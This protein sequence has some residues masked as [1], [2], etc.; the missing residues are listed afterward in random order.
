MST[1]TTFDLTG[2]SRAINGGD[3]RYHLALYADD[4]QV[5][6]LDPAHAD[7]P[8]EVLRGKPAIGA[9]LDGISSTAVRHEVTAAVVH[10]AH[11]RY[12]EE[13]Q[14]ADGSKVQLDCRAEVRR[15]QIARA[16]VRLV[17]VPRPQS[18][19]RLAQPSPTRTLDH[20]LRQ[21]APA[22]DAS[23]RGTTRSLPGNFLG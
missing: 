22:R 18:L 7:T 11:V 12:T 16:V 17:H 2:L 8:V 10:P 13:C 6:I 3:C 21:L 1:Q 15:G 5:E 23:G 20:Q 4:A 14:Y 19:P 9:W